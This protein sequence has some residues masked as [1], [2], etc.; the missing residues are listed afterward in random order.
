[1]IFPKAHI[2]NESNLFATQYVS[3]F[4]ELLYIRSI[5]YAVVLIHYF[6]RHVYLESSKY[7]KWR[8]PTIVT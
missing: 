5:R 6:V 1:M 8:L 3:L 4:R 2:S 7:L